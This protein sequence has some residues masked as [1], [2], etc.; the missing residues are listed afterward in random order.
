[1]YQLVASSTFCDWLVSVP[2]GPPL[3]AFS[4][5]WTGDGAKTKPG[6]QVVLDGD[7][8]VV[9]DAD[10]QARRDEPA[11]DLDVVLAR[12]VDRRLEEVVEPGR[13]AARALARV[14]VARALRDDVAGVVEQRDLAQPED[15]VARVV[16]VVDVERDRDR[17]G[18][19]HVRRDVELVVVRVPAAGVVDGDVRDGRGVED[20]RIGVLAPRARVEILRRTERRVERVA[21]D[22]GGAEVAEE[23]R[24]RRICRALGEELR[25]RSRRRGRRTSSA[26]S[27]S[28]SRSAGARARPARRRPRPRRR[29]ARAASSRRARRRCTCR[30]RRSGSTSR[31]SARAPSC[32]PARS[33]SSVETLKT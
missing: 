6:G 23:A 9:V 22:L 30:R 15:R 19:D 1:M 14:G 16:A 18:R 20:V 24:R 11:A 5:S 25:A 2:L 4:S 32:R 31:C 3:F 27:R 10:R 12:G 7:L 29:A 26:R 8:Q 17:A 21:V 13:A 28:W 33:C